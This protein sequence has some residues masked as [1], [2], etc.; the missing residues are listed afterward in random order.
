MK[1]ENNISLVLLADFLGSYMNNGLSKFDNVIMDIIKVYPNAI[2]IGAVAVS[3]YLRYPVQP[4][5]TYDV[6]FL[7]TADDFENFLDDEIP[8]KK[9]KILDSLF[10]DPRS[11][12]HSLLHS[13]TQVDVDLISVQSPP[14][15]KKVVNFILKNTKECIHRLNI[16]DKV[17]NVLR[18]EFVIIMKLHRHV[19]NPNSKKGISDLLDIMNIITTYINSGESLELST[20]EEFTNQREFAKYQTIYSQTKRDVE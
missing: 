5:A 3:K 17:V 6:D 18:P 16:R 9:L 12:S 14:V 4:R 20:I 15:K 8:E 19:K 13:K 10:S 7:V 1:P 11:A 2:L